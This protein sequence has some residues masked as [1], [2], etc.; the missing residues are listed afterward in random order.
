MFAR[1]DYLAAVCVYTGDTMYGD[2]GL[3]TCGTELRNNK[4]K[5]KGRNSKEQA[6][7]E[8][9]TRSKEKK[10]PNERYANGRRS[11]PTPTPHPVALNFR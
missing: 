4:K 1:T 3:E 5:K 10:N 9:K 2:S 8:R 11:V 7:N 6:R